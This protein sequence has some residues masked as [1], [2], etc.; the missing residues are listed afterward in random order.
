MDLLSLDCLFIQLSVS[1]RK[2][3]NVEDACWAG[4]Q[5]ECLPSG[6]SV[7]WGLVFHLVPEK[8]KNKI[9]YVFFFFSFIVYFLGGR[10]HHL[11]P[12]VY[13]SE[14]VLSIADASLPLFQSK[15]QPVLSLLHN[16]PVSRHFSVLLLNMA[17]LHA[18]QLLPR[19]CG[20]RDHTSQ[21]QWWRHHGD[22]P[23]ASEADIPKYEVPSPIGGRGVR[24]KNY[25]PTIT[26]CIRCTGTSRVLLRFFNLLWCFIPS[27][28]KYNSVTRVVI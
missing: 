1:N 20:C 12:P 28:L 21:H 9:L 17:W 14:C 18:S 8:G 27:V 23:G 10:S 13:S 11:L 24:Y 6:L 25:L 22:I 7:L 15:F 19:L 2:I 16:Y 3:I 4:E 5:R 26:V